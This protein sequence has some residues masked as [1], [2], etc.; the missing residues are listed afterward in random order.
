MLLTDFEWSRNPRG[1]HVPDVFTF[2]LD[3]PMYRSTNMGWVKLVAGEQEYIRVLPEL[4]ELGITPILR[5]YMPMAGNRPAR[6]DELEHY[7]AYAEAGVKWF[8][9][10]NE[11]NLNVEWPQG[12]PTIDW[13][14]PAL[15]APLCDN[16]LNWAEF[17]ISIGGY[18]GF[19]PL[20]E[21]A[22][23]ETGAVRW[24]DTML[25]YMANTHYT[26]FLNVLRGG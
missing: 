19:I 6:T 8:E 24:M 13:R 18:P 11:P 25:N 2:G 22:V 23:R 4:Y 12:T 9:F 26:R 14:N 21:S 3:V 20:A 7:R 17:I 1:M 16:W 10:Y 15:I 5:I